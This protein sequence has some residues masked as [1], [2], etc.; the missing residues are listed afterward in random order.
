MN[1]AS[2]A[3]LTAVIAIGFAACSSDADQISS[4]TAGDEFCML[5]A[6]ARTIGAAV[7][8][9]AADPAALQAQVD[10]AFDASKA[11]AAKA[12]KDFE[13]L[14]K[15]NIEQQRAVVALLQQYDY[16]WTKALTSAEGKKLFG[17][18]DYAQNKTDRDAYLQQHCDIAPTENTSGGA[19]VTLSSG[20]QGIR[21]FFQ[22]LQIGGQL[23]ITD[24]QVNCAVAA[25]SGKIS[26]ADMQA[27]GSGAAVSD[28]G[29][30]ALVESL[31]GCNIVLGG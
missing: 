4:A 25:L 10:A 15:K 27:I 21:E 9:A 7:D 30:K 26:D 8:T 24:Q 11:V 12:P 29:T 31:S 20:D 5:A 2:L 19:G 18:A 13:V 28:D 1:K 14:A 23:E 16:N 17:D 22:L 3:C 6:K